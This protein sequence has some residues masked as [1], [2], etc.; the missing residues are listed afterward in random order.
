M[1]KKTPNY[2]RPIY[3]GIVAST[4]LAL[5]VL[6]QFFEDGSTGA[7]IIMWLQTLATALGIGGVTLPTID[8]AGE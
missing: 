6:G 4:V 2:K 5:T 8:K 3:W 1:S 7:Q